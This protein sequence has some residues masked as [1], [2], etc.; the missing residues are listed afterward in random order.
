V[1]IPT[2]SKRVLLR[3]RV[4]DGVRD[5]LVSGKLKA[6]DIINEGQ[7]ATEYGI[8]KTPVREA[9]CLLSFLGLLSPLPR[10]GYIVSPITVRDVQEAYQLRTLL[11]VEAV[12]LAVDRISDEEIDRLEKL[13]DGQ[14]AAEMR[15]ANNEFH[16]MIARASGNRRLARLTEQVLDEMDRM[17]YM[18]PHISAPTGPYEHEE[19]VQALRDR[20]KDRAEEAVRR[21]IEKARARLLELL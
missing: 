9:L 3:E 6:G 19:I 2:S 13:M 14:T 1:A 15:A 7:L 21:H 20:D 18:D 8:S 4:Y 10:T 12:R 16:A 5:A 11:E 17:L